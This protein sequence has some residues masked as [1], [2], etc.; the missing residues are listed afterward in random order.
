M[1][2][3]V[4]TVVQVVDWGSVSNVV[5]VSGTN[6]LES[7]LSAAGDIYTAL[8]WVV[9]LLCALILAVTFRPWSA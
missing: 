1:E 4:D 6:T 9:G 7:L 5:F 8:L 2:G 3:I